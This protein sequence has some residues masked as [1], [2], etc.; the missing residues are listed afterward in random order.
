M[1]KPEV[2]IDELRK[3]KQQAIDDPQVQASTPGHEE[4][5][6]KVVAVLERSLGK[7]SSTVKQFKDLRYDIGFYSGAAGEA[8]RDARYFRERVKEAA[9]LI[10]AAIYELELSVGTP[11]VEGGGLG[12][13]SAGLTGSPKKWHA[14]SDR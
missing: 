10:E 7:D 8:E 5:K 3:L 11:A 1:I 6:A 9:G 13:G 12:P 2:A 14:R 4:W